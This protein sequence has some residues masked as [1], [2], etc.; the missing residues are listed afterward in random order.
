[1]EVDKDLKARVV[2]FGGRDYC[3]KDTFYKEVDEI[4]TDW[5]LT[6]DWIEIVE[7]GARGTDYLASLYAKDR[8]ISHKQFKAN[9]DK[10]GKSAGPI[11]NKEMAEYCQGQYGISF[12]DG[13]S[14]GTENMLNNC[15][16]YDIKVQGLLYNQD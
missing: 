5:G 10:Y 12:W 2:I 1:M 15:D 16:K 9:W 14:K 6:N 11:R 8:G 13:K 4:L 3:D 7:G